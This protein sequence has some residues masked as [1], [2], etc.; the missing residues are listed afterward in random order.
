MTKNKLGYIS[1]FTGAGGLDIGLDRTGFKRLLCVEVD[2]ICRAT[3]R[4]N[5]L[6]S[7]LANEGDIY[8][9]T[10]K[11]I[12]LQ[13]GIKKKQ[14]FLLVGGPPCQPF[15]KSGFWVNGETKRMEDPRANTVKEFMR[16]IGD[17]LPENII[18]ENVTG[19]SF[20]NKDEGLNYI[21]SKFKA[22]NKKTGTK[23]SPKAI[24]INAAEYGVP[25]IRQRVF[26]IANRKGK[27]F[28]KPPVT[29]RAQDDLENPKLPVFK[30]AWDAIGDLDVDISPSD[31]SINGKWAD[32][33]P[34]I[35]EGYNYLWHTER[36]KGKPLFGWRTRYWSFLLKLAKEK[37]S[38]TITAKPGP[39]IGPF[40]W[41]NRKLSIKEMARLQTFPDDYEFCGSYREQQCQIGNAVPPAIGE[42]LGL[43]L[44]RQF[45]GHKTRR[46]LRLI[47]E[48]LIYTPKRERI[49]AVPKKYFSK[50]G[51]HDEHPGTGKGPGAYKY[52]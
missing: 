42:M 33:I 52:K 4:H 37:P 19:I 32:L 24:Q 39:A 17:L 49:K 3:L 23:Y 13:A 1:L 21:I 34:S 50:I 9:L 5:D 11:E 10:S 47:P 48:I 25:Q 35:P 2:E 27:S 18:I 14:L 6:K 36:M 43:E 31:L 7:I 46:R 15:S 22:I 28:V 45:Q 20:S 29:H 38:W 26:I 30:S 12:L 40:H 16:V 41:K 51:R 8:N 44:R